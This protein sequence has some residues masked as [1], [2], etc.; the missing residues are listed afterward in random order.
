M[1]T[2]EN[3][4]SSFWM[5]I[6]LKLA[7][8]NSTMDYIIIITHSLFLDKGFI[9]LA[10]SEYLDYIRGDKVN[11]TSIPKLKLPIMHL[12][13][14]FSIDLI[15]EKWD[16]KTDKIKLF[17]TNGN[18]P[19]EENG[20]NY[21]SEVSIMALFTSSEDSFT[22]TI[23]DYNEVIHSTKINFPRKKICQFVD[24]ESLVKFLFLE[25]SNWMEN[26]MLEGIKG[27]YKINHNEVEEDNLKRN[28]LFRNK[29]TEVPFF[30]DDVNMGKEFYF[31][32]PLI[33]DKGIR[34]NL[35]GPNSLVFKKLHEK[36][37]PKSI[38]TSSIPGM[39]I[40]PDNDIYFPPGN[41]D[42]QGFY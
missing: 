2:N 16:S 15:P 30:L 3:N 27:S 24:G 11:D 34:G 29:E 14:S 38:P 32:D 1:V 5:P 9:P 13:S 17:Y 10:S 28:G 35:V 33:D 26:G 39:R 18:S 22:L 19:P 41:K 37:K 21:F 12:E 25:I 31:P 6:L 4:K 40:I 7:R 20:T 36:V 42:F 8:P 23:E